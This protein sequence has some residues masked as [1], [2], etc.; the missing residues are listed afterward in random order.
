[1]HARSPEQLPELERRL[2]RWVREG[3]ISEETA[4]AIWDLERASPT[5]TAEAPAPT[6][7]ARRV[8][9]LTEVIGYL[10]AAL[11][12]AAVAVFVTRTWDELT[13]WQRLTTAGA[14]GLAF[15]GAGSAIHRSR[16][17]AVQR[18]AALLWLI[19]TGAGAGFAGIVAADVADVADRQ[20]LVWV[21][22]TSA[23]LGGVLYAY[24]RWALLQLALVGGLAMLVGA[25]LF[26][27]PF[28][29]GLGLTALGAAWAVLGALRVLAPPSASLAIGS[30]LALWG[31]MPVIDGSTGLGLSVGVA[32]AAGVLGL[33]AL[34]RQP[35][36]LGIGVV[37][38]FLYLVNTIGHF[39][40]GSAATALGLLVVGL[41]LIALAVI[42]TRMRPRRGP[43]RPAHG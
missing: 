41:A 16:E 28:R 43:P 20:V 22:A 42:G 5:A 1:M 6:P 25:A 26:D 10:G 40:E 3:L 38:L 32:V 14:G 24:R 12:A 21:G 18:L 23:L 7:T 39:L 19:G 11:A 15:L 31:P 29:I 27:H 30:I 13:T 35:V 8:P 2:H 4:A 33:G 9:V 36:V 17:P 37:G 34:A